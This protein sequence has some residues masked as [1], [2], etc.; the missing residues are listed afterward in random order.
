[1][2]GYKIEG[3]YRKDLRGWWDES[4]RHRLARMG[5]KG[6]KANSYLMGATLWNEKVRKMSLNEFLNTDFDNDGVPNK[7]DKY[8]F[9]PVN[10]R[11]KVDFSKK[12]KDKYDI[13]KDFFLKGERS[14]QPRVRNGKQGNVFRAVSDIM[15]PLPE[16][17]YTRELRDELEV[18]GHVVAYE[19]KT[20]E[21]MI[22]EL[23]DIMDVWEK[24]G[25]NKPND[26]P[27]GEDKE[28][29]R[30]LLK[31]LGLKVDFSKSDVD[32]SFK[33]WKERQKIGFDISMRKHPY[34]TL[35]T[36]GTP[37]L[38]ALVLVKG[39][40]QKIALPLVTPI[41]FKVQEKIREWQERK[42]PVNIEELKVINPKPHDFLIKS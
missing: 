6:I 18:P 21:Q 20:K 4:E 26:V 11:Y 29:Y 36:I 37:I 33:E 7:Y 42:R 31:G 12:R 2:K 9:N 19:I 34:M 41:P 22:K 39:N 23:R 16:I 25:Y 40:P 27:E 32:Y 35:A 14:V 38:I 15:T 30:E 28:R 1:M 24:K 3:K 13:E 8:P 5:V 17:E 10:Y